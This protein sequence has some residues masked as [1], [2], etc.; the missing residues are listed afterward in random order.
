[1]G[2][3]IPACEPDVQLD[4]PPI[5]PREYIYNLVPLSKPKV[6][7]KFTC[8]P[9]IR[10]IPK[11]QNNLLKRESM[12]TMGPPHLDQLSPIIYPDK[13]PYTLKQSKKPYVKLVN[14][15]V[16]DC[17]KAAKKQAAEAEGHGQP[18]RSSCLTSP[19]APLP[20]LQGTRQIGEVK[21][22]PVKC[23]KREVNN[24]NWITRNAIVAITSKPGYRFPP[25]NRRQIVDTRK[26][27]K[28]HLKSQRTSSGVE[29]MYVYKHGLGEVPGYILKWNKMMKKTQGLLTMYINEKEVQSTD[30]FLTEEQ[31]EKLLNGL[32]A[33]WDRYN[34][35][36]LGLAS[37]NDTLKGKAY[38]AYLEHQ[39]DMLKADIELVEGHRFLFVESP[40]NPEAAARSV[41]E[42]ICS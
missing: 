34:R 6:I 13:R 1:M 40:R 18:A 9:K 29:P 33:A 38:K 3:A 2:P 22:V 11:K 39:L 15:T 31:R 5:G 23:V 7:S 37:I 24:V 12:K 35:R 32:K 21:D 10:A 42:S 20:S 36:Y 28:F 16:Q 14:H 8:L 4:N 25:I 41:S 30:F 19:K 27:D 17:L 26:G